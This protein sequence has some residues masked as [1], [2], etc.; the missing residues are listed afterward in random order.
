MVMDK[1]KYELEKLANRKTGYPIATIAYY[2]PNDQF[3]SKVVVGIQLSE[4][5]QEVLHLRR[6]FAKEQDVRLDM[7]ILKEILEYIRLYR[8]RRVAMVDR[9]IGC[10]HEE[11]VDY[12]MGEV[13]PYCPFWANRDRWTGELIG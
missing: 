1:S 5:V 3:A 12:P 2:G 6:W 9:I 10:P 4:E 8:S 11:G 7:T 13:C